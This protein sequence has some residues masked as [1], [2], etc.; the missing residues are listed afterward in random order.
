MNQYPDKEQTLILLKEWEN[1]W[2]SL[3]KIDYQLE[4]EMLSDEFRN[5]IY[6]TFELLFEKYTKELQFRICGID[7]GWLG[8]FC[9]SYNMG[10]REATFVL[11]N[12]KRTISTIENLCDLLIKLRDHK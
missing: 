10:E 12:E 5:L 1:L 2:F 7:K 8:W 3:D 9:Y 11:N 6:N 4:V